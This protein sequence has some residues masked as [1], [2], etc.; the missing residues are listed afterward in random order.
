MGMEKHRAIPKGYMT[1]GELAK[2]M[3]VTVRTLHHYDKTGLLSPSSESEGGFRLYNAKDMVKLNQILAMKHLGFSLD[4]IKNR[5]TN[6]DTP[7]DVADA[8][9]E[10]AASIREKMDT[11]SA[12]L[13]AIEALRAEVMQMQS[14]DFGKYADIIVSL[15]MKNEHYWVIKHLDD[16]FLDHIQDR[17]A[18]AG[19]DMGI[20]DTFSRLQ[21]EAIRL[22]AEGVPPDSEEGLAFAHEFWDMITTFTGG[23]MTLLPKMLALDESIDTMDGWDAAWKEKYEKARNF[24]EP[25]TEAYLVA[26]FG[27]NPFE[28]EQS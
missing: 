5:L 11:L 7:A 8:L 16:Q 25:A 21:D 26:T 23:D 19:H 4:D 20:V 3:N 9:A 12:S 10:H 1:V 6:L 17:F 13:E 22:Q 14:V 24:I 28:E 15:Q 2:Q 18:D 27:R